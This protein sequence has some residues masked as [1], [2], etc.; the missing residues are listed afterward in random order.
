MDIVDGR[1]YRLII[2]SE[3]QSADH[4]RTVI[5]YNLGV[6]EGPDV[7]INITGGAEARRA[8][9]TMQAGDIPASRLPQS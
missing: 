6:P 1:K 7:A 2:I 5:C 4:L 9:I 3:V 8:R